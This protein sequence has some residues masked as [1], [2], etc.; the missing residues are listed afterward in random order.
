MWHFSKKSCR[1]WQWFLWTWGRG[2][3]EKA[4]WFPV[5]WCGSCQSDLRIP[6]IPYGW[7]SKPLTKFLYELKLYEPLLVPAGPAVHV[8]QILMV[9]I[10][11]VTQPMV[12]SWNIPSMGSSGVSHFRTSFSGDELPSSGR[13]SSDPAHQLPILSAL[14]ILGSSEQSSCFPL[15]PFGGFP[16][17]FIYAYANCLGRS[18]ERSWQVGVPREYEMLPTVQMPMLNCTPP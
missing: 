18:E 5:A 16:V 9:N 8:G 3:T 1:T 4:P 17:G 7:T 11:L 6:I 12:T 10:L 15:D 13:R 2:T 14:K